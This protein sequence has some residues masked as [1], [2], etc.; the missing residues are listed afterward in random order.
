MV[1]AVGAS[2][3]QTLNNN[4]QITSSLAKD[5]N[6]FLTMLTTQLKNQDPLSPMDSTDFT[7]QLVQFAGV[8][9][10]IN[11]NTT[12]KELM[13]MQKLNQSTTAIGYLGKDV[14]ALSNLL[15]LQNG[16]SRFSATLQTDSAAAN[17]VIRDSTGAIVKTI[18]ANG[19]AGRQE[20]TWDG[21]D[22][23]GNQ[24]DDGVFTIEIVAKDAD[25]KTVEGYTTV[26]GRVSD[27]ATDSSGTLLGIGKMAVSLDQILTVSEPKNKTEKPETPPD[28]GD[29]PKPEQ[30]LPKPDDE[31]DPTPEQ[32]LP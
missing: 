28:D 27:V 29:D 3:N 15:P 1:D 5:F 32:P 23:D 2:G 25:G 20:F 26:Y 16:Q 14:E 7:N 24:L 30:P 4:G 22:S 13:A 12:L 9:Q 6:T 21:K 17:I 18:A 11:T 19:N 10:Q 8:E 31:D